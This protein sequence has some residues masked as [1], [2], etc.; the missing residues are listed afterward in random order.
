MSMKKKK[1]KKSSSLTP[2]SNPAQQ[3]ALPLSRSSQKSGPATV[4]TSVGSLLGK[5][6]SYLLSGKPAEA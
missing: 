2:G 4:D 6:K 5:V 3:P 1:A